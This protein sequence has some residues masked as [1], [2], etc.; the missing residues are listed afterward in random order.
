MHLWRAVDDGGE[1]PDVLVQ[2][3]RNKAAGR[4]AGAVSERDVAR[5]ED[6][7]AVGNP[8]SNG[9]KPARACENCSAW[10]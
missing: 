2:K 5:L 8:G 7:K 9:L 4:V 10:S 1:V 6:R 3:R